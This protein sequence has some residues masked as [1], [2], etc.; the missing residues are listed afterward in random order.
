MD[1]M[2]RFDRLF[3]I[4]L[5]LRGGHAVPAAEFARRFGISRRTV[6]RDMDTLSALG[7]PVYAER[8]RGGGFR[9]LA[10]YFLPPIMFS[11]EEAIS[12]VLGLTLLGSLRAAPYAT[13]QETAEHKLLAAVPERLRATLASARQIIG[14]ERVPDDIFHPE[15]PNPALLASVTPDE[16]EIVSAFLRA[17]LERRRVTLDYRSPYRGAARPVTLSPYGLFWD[18]D[19]WYLVGAREA[20]DAP[21]LWRAD[22]VTAIAVD[23]LAAASP[24]VFDIR[25]LLGWHWL[26]TA[27]T[28][29]ANNAPVRIRVTREQAD[30]LR[31][32]WLYRHARYESAPDGAI[33]VT[34]GEDDPAY[35]LELIRWLG[36]GAELLEPVAWRG[37]L[38]AELAAMLDTY[39]DDDERAENMTYR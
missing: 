19:R 24:P 13:E 20:K 10:G 25:T 32:D 39:A 12:L 7:I 33:V 30:R 9:L 22:R 4:L 21:G 31:R 38:R 17:I 26:G 11:E 36:P 29:W 16:Q 27:M 6:H 15:P 34:I 1:G 23:T 2:R 37:L 18:R 28:E 35:F 14:F 3:G 5:L 8:G